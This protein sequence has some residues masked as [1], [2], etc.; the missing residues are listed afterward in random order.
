MKYLLKYE[1]NT[2]TI[3][4]SSV[5]AISIVLYL[6]V[7]FVEIIKYIEANNRMIKILSMF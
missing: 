5:S 1:H 2:D 7:F 4:S 6:Q 3:K